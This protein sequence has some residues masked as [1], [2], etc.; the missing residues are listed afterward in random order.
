MERGALAAAIMDHPREFVGIVMA[1]AAAVAI[2]VNALFLQRGPHPAPIFAASPPAAHRPAVTLRPQADLGQATPDAAA[3]SRGEVVTGIQRELAARGFYDGAVDG[4]WGSKTDSA[5]HD[6]ALA[7]GLN[8]GPE[9]SA[10]LLRTIVASPVRRNAAPAPAR[11][12]PIAQLLAPSKR[13]LA[14]QS[15]LSDFGY[16]QLKPSGV[17]D[18]DTRA[19]IEKFERDRRMPVTGQLTDGVV[20]EIA[21]VTGRLLE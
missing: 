13:I 2:F 9:A 3:P 7:A 21:A 18:A 8:I 19:A 20:R 6:F 5:V 15:A 17:L 1:A 14:V 12:D 10:G 16:G 4:I 11:N